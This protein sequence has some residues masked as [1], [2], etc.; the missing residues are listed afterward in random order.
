M[1]LTPDFPA[2]EEDEGHHTKATHNDD[3]AHFAQ[4]AAS[5]AISCVTR[6]RLSDA[7]YD[8]REASNDDQVQDSGYTRAHEAT[9][10]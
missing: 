10:V 9:M 7:S 3:S 2:Q 8:K 6:S 5:T 4:R 1:E